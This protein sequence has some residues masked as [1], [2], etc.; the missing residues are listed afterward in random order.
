MTETLADM[1]NQ[2][3]KQLQLISIDENANHFQIKG[4]DISVT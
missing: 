1:K 3:I 4:K 2:K